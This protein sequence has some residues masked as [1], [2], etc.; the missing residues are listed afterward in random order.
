MNSTENTV[1]LTKI[2]YF[3]GANYSRISEFE[4]AETKPRGAGQ[5]N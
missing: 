1:S 3:N 5:N 2:W 4:A